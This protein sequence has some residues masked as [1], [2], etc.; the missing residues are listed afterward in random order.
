ME[1]WHKE[2]TVP[3]SAGKTFN[4]PT[5]NDRVYKPGST[6]KRLA[7]AAGSS[8]VVSDCHRRD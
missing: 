4:W 1:K 5:Y 8:G 7:L 2:V 6:Q 3:G